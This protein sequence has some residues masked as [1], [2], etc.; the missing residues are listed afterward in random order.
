VVGEPDQ[1]W[2]VL[3]EQVA[4]DAGG[5]TDHEPEQY[6]GVERHASPFAGASFHLM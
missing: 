6:L 5:G 2:N 4:G 3:P 1:R